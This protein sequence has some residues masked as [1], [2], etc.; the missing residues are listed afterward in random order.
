MI[1]NPIVDHAWHGRACLIVGSGPSAAKAPKTW[2]HG[3]MITV[4]RAGDDRP[5]ADLWLGVDR[6]FW[7]ARDDEPLRSFGPT[8]VWV[9]P[10]GPPLQPADLVDVEIPQAGESHEEG[11]TRSLADGIYCAG[12]SGYAA[13]QLAYH[14]GADPVYCVGLDCRHPIGAP[15]PLKPPQATLDR[16]MA[17]QLR[18][19][20]R[21]A[22]AGRRVHW[23]DGGA[24]APREVLDG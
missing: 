18:L 8:R 21:F 23:I 16:W 15:A 13:L 14:L 9:R 1:D 7:E 2:R 3:C 19:A 22:E 24:A 17:A 11:L 5:G 6:P 20:A 10:P 12:N 4:S